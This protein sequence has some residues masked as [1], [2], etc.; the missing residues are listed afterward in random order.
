MLGLFVDF[1]LRMIRAEV[2]LGTGL[3]LP[4]LRRGEAVTGMAG[5][6]GTQGAIKIQPTNP[7]IRPGQR[8]RTAFF[9]H[10]DR[11]AVALQTAGI[12]RGRTTDHF[13]HDVI[14]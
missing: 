8:R 2:A 13:A 4:C 10:L 12:D 9:V 7:G 11:A 5:R 3:R 6:A 1:L 14:Q